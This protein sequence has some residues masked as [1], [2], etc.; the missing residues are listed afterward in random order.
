MNVYETNG[1]AAPVYNPVDTPG[2]NPWGQPYPSGSYRNPTPPKPPAQ[3]YASG[4]AK[5]SSG[6]KSPAP[7]APPDPWAGV[8]GAVRDQA[9]ALVDKFLST[10]G[11]PQ[12]IDA[13]ALAQKLAK[14]GT[15]ITGSPL[16]AYQW[17][18]SNGITEQQQLAMP[19]AQF[20]MGKDDYGQTVAKLDSVYASWTGEKLSTQNL[21]GNG[22]LWGGS[23][24]W[25]AIRGSWT[26]D[27]IK[28]FAMFG[29]AEGTGPLLESAQLTGDNPWLSEGQ[30]YQQ[31]LE[32]FQAF[33]GHTPTDKAT[34]GAWFRFGASTK[35]LSAGR[36]A[37]G[38]VAQK[39][40]VTA[41]EVR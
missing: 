11:Y 28:N 29:N 27:Q 37:V 7:A 30:T 32:G 8:P 26:P 34:L 2:L 15:N 3:S 10:I 12:G 4:P 23:P 20:G 9:N 13:T 16:D 18:Y 33:E 22:G 38:T 25:Q 17:L 36:G 31:T 35:S 1:G 6:S 21:G 40:L 5:R 14:S 41:S 19:W 39:P 24:M